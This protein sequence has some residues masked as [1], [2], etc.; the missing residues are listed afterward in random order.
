MF[1]ANQC[2]RVKNWKFNPILKSKDGNLHEFW[3]K[4][5]KKEIIEKLNKVVQLLK[6]E[7]TKTKKSPSSSYSYQTTLMESF[8]RTYS[9]VE[10]LSSIFERRK[11]GETS[12]SRINI[13]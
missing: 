10:K 5:R 6:D 2:S 9:L 8:K 7:E 4:S 1:F 3:E 12:T 13:K 11:G